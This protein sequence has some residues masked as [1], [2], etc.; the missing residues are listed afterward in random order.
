MIRHDLLLLALWARVD[1]LSVVTTGSTTLGASGSTYTRASGSFITDGFAPGMET[2]DWNSALRVVEKVEALTLTVDSAPTAASQASGRTLAV[3][4]PSRFAHEN[5]HF[6]PT[7]GYPWLEDALISGPTRQLT[8]GTSEATI[9]WDPI[10]RLW[11]HVPEN[12]GSLA[13]L[14]YVDALL[15]HLRSNTSVTLTG[16][17]TVHVRTDAGPYVGAIVRQRP[18]F[19]TA[20]LT[21]NMRQHLLN[22]A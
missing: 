1:T 7:Q 11:V 19:V 10:Y 21:V 2:L 4:P 8:T 3:G 9:E 14:K 15:L 18:G 16:G 12:V 6:D 5:V 22:A 17:A 13:A 20:L